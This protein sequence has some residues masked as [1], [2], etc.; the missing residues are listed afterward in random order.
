[1]QSLSLLFS[2]AGSVDSSPDC[3]SSGLT[4]LVSWENEKICLFCGVNDRN[5]NVIEVVSRCLHAH[6]NAWSGHLPAV[7]A[8]FLKDPFTGAELLHCAWN[9]FVIVPCLSLPP[10]PVLFFFQNCVCLRWNSMG[11]AVAGMMAAEALGGFQPIKNTEWF[12]LVS[13][14]RK[15]RNGVAW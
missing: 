8:I 14:G 5:R 12:F 4:L 9:S 1:M 10:A 11:R 3:E 13:F 2:W 6:T 15:L 7:P